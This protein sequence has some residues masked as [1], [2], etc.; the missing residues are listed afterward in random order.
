MTEIL[1]RFG[2]NVPSHKTKWEFILLRFAATVASAAAPQTTEVKAGLR[3]KLK[4]VVLAYSGGLD[5]SVIVPWLKLV[6]C[7]TLLKKQLLLHAFAE[8]TV[9]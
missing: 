3:G 1:V 7:L 6:C 9:A 2:L 8:R 4:K 5:T